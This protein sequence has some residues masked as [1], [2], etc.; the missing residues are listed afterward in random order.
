MKSIR[1]SYLFW[2]RLIL[3]SCQ[4]RST[5]WV[6][7]RWGIL[8]PWWLV[9]STLKRSEAE[10]IL[11][12]FWAEWES[13]GQ[14]KSVVN[15]RKVGY[16]ASADTHPRCHYMW[17]PPRVKWE[18]W[19]SPKTWRALAG[20][21]ALG[22]HLSRQRCT[23]RTPQG[24]QRGCLTGVPGP[25]MLGT[26]SEHRLHTQTVCSSTNQNSLCVCN[27]GTFGVTLY[28]SQNW[29]T[30]TSTEARESSSQSM[31]SSL[32]SEAPS[33]ALELMG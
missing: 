22:G 9:L 26:P 1:R 23:G 14:E 18:G 15:T 33:F 25:S 2:A 28:I 7:S 13:T 29:P 16:G 30:R 12:H 3:H 27:S 24:P 8:P 20:M 10:G 31:S 19:G 17:A 5:I 11:T 4:T 6:A 21:Q 32:S